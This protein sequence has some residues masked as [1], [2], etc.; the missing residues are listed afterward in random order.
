MSTEAST[1]SRPRISAAAGQYSSKLDATQGAL[2]TASDGNLVSETTGDY[3]VLT[4]PPH[5]QEDREIAQQKSKK[6]SK[7]PAIIGLP[8][9]K[10]GATALDDPCAR[11]PFL[12]ILRNRFSGS[13]RPP[14]DV[15]DPEVVARRKLRARVVQQREKAGKVDVKILG[16]IQKYHG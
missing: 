9:A 4:T 3:I 5:D 12:K 13:S 2:R 15:E 16:E 10:N 14:V 6:T 11:K 8:E 7:G 1:L